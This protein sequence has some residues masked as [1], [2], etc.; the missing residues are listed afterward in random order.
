MEFLSTAAIIGIVVCIL[1]LGFYFRRLYKN[2]NKTIQPLLI[3]LA[4]AIFLDLIPNITPLY[5]IFYGLKPRWLEIIEIGAYPFAMMLG[6]FI[7]YEL[8][9]TRTFSFMDMVRTRIFLV[10]ICLVSIPIGITCFSLINAS[11]TQG[12][13]FEKKISYYIAYFFYYFCQIYV[14]AQTI[15]V[16]TKE[17]KQEHKI[18]YKARIIVCMSGFVSVLLFYVLAEINLFLSFFIQDNYRLFINS[19]VQDFGK[20][21]SL[22]ILLI[23]FVFPRKFY[24]IVTAPIVQYISQKEQRNIQLL[25]RYCALLTHIVPRNVLKYKYIHP[26]H[27]FMLIYDA[28]KVIWSHGSSR[29]TS[30]KK[31]AR[32]IALLLR[33]GATITKMGPHIHPLGKRDF[34]RHHLSIARHLQRMEGIDAHSY[35]AH[36][37]SATSR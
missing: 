36:G 22:I 11:F 13:L 19:I 18:D 4:I 24:I 37:G 5:N 34:M 7:V 10:F 12:S 23:G 9:Y 8:L 31:L 20:G 16:Y 25:N 14:L 15:H 3:K 27:I 1:G 6:Y 32:H 17:V 28:D 2:R 21:L 35:S 26:D 33:S 30:P 29:P